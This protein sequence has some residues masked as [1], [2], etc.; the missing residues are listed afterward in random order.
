MNDKVHPSSSSRG[1]RPEAAER[2]PA[3]GPPRGDG[4]PTIRGARNEDLD[5]LVDLYLELKE[6]HARLAPRNPRYRV[7]RSGWERVVRRALDDPGMTIL[8]AE[9]EG[10]VVGFVKLSIV[11][12]PWGLA[13]EID[14]MVVA[15]AHRG[16]GWGARLLAA[17][18]EHAVNAGARGLRL[19][20][21]AGNEAGRRFYERAGFSPFAIRYGKDVP[22]PAEE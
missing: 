14:T 21:L 7:E 22:Q 19:D 12:K 9:A 20:V 6:H 2:R 3:D 17:A 1:V 15:E 13:G 11:I 18:E 5:S 4:S 16:R 8:V 10:R